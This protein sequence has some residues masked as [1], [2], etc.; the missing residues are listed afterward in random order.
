M[1][2][3]N[4]KVGQHIVYATNGLCCIEDIQ[5]I[6]FIKGEESK[7]H[8][9]I[10]PVNGNSSKIYV[11][12]DSDKLMSKIRPAMTKQDIDTLLSGLKN[13]EMA[14]EDDRKLRTEN[15]HDLLVNGVNEDLILMISCVYL[16]KHELLSINKT[17]SASDSKFLENAEK[18]VV[19][20]FSYALDIPPSEVGKYIRGKLGL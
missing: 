11:P 6:S 19:E 5:Y 16:K 15:F 18:L 3:E 2:N 1:A 13:K 7:K 12:A 17:I 8:Y 20:E 10:K 9:I 14:W 4:Y